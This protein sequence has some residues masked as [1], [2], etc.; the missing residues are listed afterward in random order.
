MKTTELIVEVFVGGTLVLVAMAFG[1]WSWFPA[2]AEW[3][4]GRYTKELVPSFGAAVPVVLA[5]LAYAMGIIA[6]F[7]ARGLLEWRLD[8]VKLARF[9]NF[10]ADNEELLKNDPLLGRF[11]R[12]LPQREPR[13]KDGRK[14][15][16]DAVTRIVGLMRF[17][18]MHR[19]P[20]LSRAVES[21]VKRMRVLRM[22]A[23][24]QALF[25]VGVL[26]RC[27]FP[28]SGI[29]GVI[30]VI[31]LGMV[32]VTYFAIQD[33]FNRYCREIERGYLVLSAQAPAT[34][35]PLGPCAAE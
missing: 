17:A 7:T 16:R 15:Y 1:L 11:F 35:V 34:G 23:L 4:L 32:V 28:P 2:A 19:S 13:S 10:R 5:A 18:V 31:V 26:P 25:L 8:R 14:R 27:F 9:E 3:A 20:D 29:V 22:L 24:V 6:E 12:A 21:H 30:C 33:R